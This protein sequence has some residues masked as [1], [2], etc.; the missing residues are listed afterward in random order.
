MHLVCVPNLFFLWMRMDV[1]AH[2][3]LAVQ[4][5]T[6][7]FTPFCHAIFCCIHHSHFQPR[8]FFGGLAKPNWLAEICCG[9]K[10]VKDACRLNACWFCRLILIYVFFRLLIF[11]HHAVY[12]LFS[13]HA[14]KIYLAAEA[15]VYLTACEYTF[16]VGLWSTHEQL[17]Y[18]SHAWSW[19]TAVPSREEFHFFFWLYI[20]FWESYFS[21]IFR[22]RIVFDR[23]PTSESTTLRQSNQRFAFLV[24]VTH[25]KKQQQ[26]FFIYFYIVNS[27]FFDF[28]GMYIFVAFGSFL[29]L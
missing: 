8:S 23:P 14:G 13:A 29:F 25:W 20:L 2:R 6:I 28:C 21:V 10:F 15:A 27:L 18:I 5:S 4:I 19:F 24:K 16:F 3:L 11:H 9:E 12:L 1:Q 26:P 22:S 7:Y 17:F